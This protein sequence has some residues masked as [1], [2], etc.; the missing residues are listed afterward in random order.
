M[1]NERL[2]TFTTGERVRVVPLNDRPGRVISGQ[3]SGRTRRP[4]YL[5]RYEIDN[6]GNKHYESSLFFRDELKP[7]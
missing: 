4:L 6:G 1:M 2:M 7:G 5:V 3:D